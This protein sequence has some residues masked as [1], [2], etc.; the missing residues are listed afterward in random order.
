[1]TNSRPMY[2]YKHLLESRDPRQRMRE[3]GFCLRYS[4]SRSVDSA[5]LI[6]SGSKGAQKDS[7]LDWR[8][9]VLVGF[10]A[11][12]EVR[13]SRSLAGQGNRDDCY[14]CYYF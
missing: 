10:V 13:H 1:M 5:F 8:G 4:S 14:H 9:L 7:W 2:L 11:Y 6:V 12:Q 3:C